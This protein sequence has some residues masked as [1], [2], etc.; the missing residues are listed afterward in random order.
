MFYAVHRARSRWEGA[1]LGVSF[2]LGEA[3]VCF[4]GSVSWG[5]QVPIVLTLLCVA[6]HHLPLALWA[7]WAPGA[8]RLRWLWVGTLG[9]SATANALAELVGIPSREAVVL[10]TTLPELVG[11]ARLFGADL[12]TA[13][14]EAGLLISAYA[15]A[16][17]PTSSSKLDVLR[18]AA[19]PAGLA[20]LLLAGSSGLA[21]ATSAPATGSLL[22]GV[23][24]IN[25]DATYYKSR[26]LAPGL[27]DAF[28]RQFNQ[29]NQSLQR[30][31]LVVATEGFDG[32]FG[33]MLPA[34]RDAWA[35]RARRQSQAWLLT[36]YIVKADG[37]KSNA[38]GAF[39]ADG[40]FVGVHEKVDLAPFGEPDLA[41]G[42][43]YRPLQLS[44][45]VALGVLICQ[46]SYLQRGSL[47]L[48]RA[49][50]TLLATTTSDV[51][52][53]S[54]TTVI[55]HLAMAQLRA[56]EAGRSMIWAS[57]A[58][59]SG[60]IDRRG[61]FEAGP[62]R[63]PFPVA[64]DA[65]L[66]SDLTPF[67]RFAPFWLWLGPA[68]LIIGSITARRGTAAAALA[69]ISF[70]PEK[71]LW[72]ALLGAVYLVLAVTTALGSPAAVEACWG[73]PARAWSA[74]PDLLASP[75]TIREPHAYEKF[76]RPA[77][78]SAEGAT[79]YLLEYYGLDRDDSQLLQRLPNAPSLDIVAGFLK[80]HYGLASRRVRLDGELPLTPMLLRS[81]QG[82]FAVVDYAGSGHGG[83]IDFASGQSRII[84][85]AELAKL[86]GLEGLFPYA[87]P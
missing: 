21:S 71:R 70:G 58:G 63:T 10:V 25:A 44:P 22:V 28:D 48:A 42:K 40:R 34:V 5:V 32:R 39:T 20:L 61:R 3:G 52:F 6:S 7:R 73:R 67:H 49:G 8:L 16:S 86:E 43:E 76:W 15:A 12:I 83:L 82:H 47:R 17:A 64:A 72:R 30:A 1:L 56:I 41:A 14:I 53:G 2:G 11:G 4:S 23:P 60:V 77:E 45:G 54:S 50:A 38:A 26:L 75:T 84:A 13:T 81:A 62:F 79:A 27:A 29:L 31:Q 80:S 78:R 51:T 18:R 59:P 19:R 68:L 57:N 65:S 66:Y 37:R 69:P 36:S 9:F 35:E 87:Q 55:E 33:L 85:A 74:L 46:E 24:Q